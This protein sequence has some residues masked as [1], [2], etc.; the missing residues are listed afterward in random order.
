MIGIGDCR[1]FFLPATAAENSRFVS[2]N[3]DFGPP[4]LRHRLPGHTAQL[5]TP[6]E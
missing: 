3:P 1:L 2:L 5:N 4:P 6:T